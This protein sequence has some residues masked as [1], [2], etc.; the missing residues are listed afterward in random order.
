VDYT[1]PDNNPDLP[2]VWR[3]A[4]WAKPGGIIAMALPGR[5]LFKQSEQGKAARAALLQGLAVTG[6]INGSNLPETAVWPKMKQPFIL[7]FARNAVAVPNHH[8]YFA[9]PVRERKL[10]DL[11]LFRIDYQ[12]A[13]PVAVQVV[14]EK[15]WLLKA[16]ANGTSLDVEVM[17][18]LTTPGWTSLGWFWRES[19]LYSGM[20]YILSPGLAQS[21][22]DHLIN[23]LDFEQPETGFHIDYKKLAT[24]QE[25]HRRKT[26]HMPRHEWLYQQ[27]LLIIPQSPGERRDSPKSYLS[28][29]KPICFSQSYYGFSAAGHPHGDVL[30]SLLYLITH[31]LLFNYFCLI[32][33]S[34]LAGCGKTNVSQS[35]I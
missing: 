16:L 5:I 12:A 2:F 35:I 7:F 23:L 15:P 32:V 17:N 31:S 9:T 18:S 28:T 11:G 30:V 1:N 6:I 25:N 19:G 24:W 20:G 21:P 13:E 14:I 29:A 34:R 26:A 4:E 3:A 33:S 27:P 10:N 8:F 22:A